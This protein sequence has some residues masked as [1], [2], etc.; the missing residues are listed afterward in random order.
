MAEMLGSAQGADE[1]VLGDELL[2]VSILSA[3][4]KRKRNE[5]LT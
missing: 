2:E 3:R 1:E 5:E 4:S